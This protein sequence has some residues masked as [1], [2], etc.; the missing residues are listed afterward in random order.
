M[1]EKVVAEF[2]TRWQACLL[3]GHLKD[4]GIQ[5][6]LHGT[7]AGEA[8]AMGGGI[9][10]GYS[11]RVPAEQQEQALRIIAELRDDSRQPWQCGRCDEINE[12]SFDICWAC[13]GQQKKPV[14]EGN[15]GSSESPINPDSTRLE[16]DDGNPYR[17][18]C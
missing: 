11:I 6:R 2:L 9:T 15:Q 18:P 4:A 10:D 16:D 8:F 14:P 13:G 17:P 3:Q 12:G 1:N 7:S 5:A